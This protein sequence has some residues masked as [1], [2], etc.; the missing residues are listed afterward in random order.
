MTN[1][2]KMAIDQST[3]LA[4]SA[5]GISKSY[6]G[7]KALSG[8][9]IHVAN[10]SIHAIVGENGA[11]KSTLI[12]CIS[13]SLKPDAGTI[14]V[15]DRELGHL[16]PSLAKELGIAVVHQE[17]SLFPALTVAENIC[18]VRGV[19]G[20][21]VNWGVIRREGAEALNQF[22]L[23]GI[24][25]RARLDQLPIGQQQLVEIARAML[26]GASLVVLDEP[27]SSLG[28]EEVD[29]LFG[30]VHEMTERGVAFI[31]ITHFLEDV[32]QH[33]D[34]V[35]VL[36]DGQL[37][38]TSSTSDVTKHDLVEAMIGDTSSVLQA[39]YEGLE[40]SLPERTT[41][42]A[43]LELEEIRLPPVVKAMTLDVHRGEVVGVYGDLGAGHDRMAEFLFGLHG[44]PASGSLKVNG[45][46]V[47]L[48]STTSARA[49]GVGFIPGDR[50]DALALQHPTAWNTSLAHLNKL[51]GFFMRRQ[52][53]RVHLSK[54]TKRL[55][56]RGIRDHHAPVGS[57]SGGNQQKALFARWLEYPPSALVIVEPTRGM[58]VGAKSDVVRIVR[59][60]ADGGTGVLII[61]SEPE[62][63][64][65]FSDRVLVAHRG[66]IVSEFAGEP[67]SK[68]QLM[69][70]A[71]GITK[72]EAA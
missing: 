9:D 43:V 37:V 63:I 16:T 49:Q 53:E 14:R 69:A 38:A 8:V 41:E 24:D 61:S 1:L 46:T 57:L 23:V 2:P 18:G 27:T 22:G 19:G 58:D 13:G 45:K 54:W 15:G 44:K 6:D 34:H 62:T 68:H 17:L 5:E 39:T 29:L 59:E 25:P 33:A 55:N 32:M 64:L 20:P 67:V 7:V 31:L 11:G 60:L 52:A 56:I 47:K 40:V 50:R 26:S 35:T 71:H 3:K 28:Q 51:T 42:P 70:A 72:L 30:F 36:R 12:K 66:R 10:A 48:A 4:L 65:T 21:F